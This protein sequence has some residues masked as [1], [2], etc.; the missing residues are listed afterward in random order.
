MILKVCGMRDPG[1]IRELVRIK[2]DWMGLI[3]YSGSARWVHTPAPA[4]PSIKR[5]G[6]FVDSSK[7]EIVRMAETNDLDLIQLHG[8]E[9]PGFC[10]DIIK[11]GF[12]VV[13][14]FALHEEFDFTSLKEYHFC[15]YFLFDTLGAL[16]GGNGVPFN[17]EWLSSYRGNVP[18][19]LSGGIGP[20]SIPRLKGFSHPRWIGIDVNS[21]FEITPGFKDIEKIKE[22]KDAIFS[23]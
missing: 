11:E 2:P 8:K 10:L 19:L 23:G 21:R 7:S 6:V 4:S 14:A 16:P 5:V 22:F 12:K 18:F 15:D 13:K 3:F 20:E 9:T 1:N 17:W